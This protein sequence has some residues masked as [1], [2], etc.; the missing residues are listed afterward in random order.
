M[1]ILNYYDKINQINDRPYPLDT[2]QLDRDIQH[3]NGP[4]NNAKYIIGRYLAGELTVVD[5]LASK[6]CVLSLMEKGFLSC[7]HK[8]HDNITGL[9][10]LAEFLGIPYQG[11]NLDPERVYHP[12]D[13]FFWRYVE[14]RAWWRLPVIFIANLWT[15][16]TH[17]KVRNGVEI[18]KTD[19]EFQVIM[20]HVAALNDTWLGRR[21]GELCHKFLRH[22]FGD[23]LREMVWL[24]HANDRNHPVRTAWE[25]IDYNCEWW[26]IK[27]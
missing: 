20:M 18:V 2:F 14:D 24:F 1:E 25:A 5:I 17:I 13:M 10:F 7:P 9:V 12:R 23:Y 22:R 15:C 26:E 4:L 3:D 27:E 11:I 21:V 16:Y 19:N 8:S 6:N